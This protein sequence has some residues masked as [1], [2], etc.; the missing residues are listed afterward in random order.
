HPRP[1]PAHSGHAQIEQRYIGLVHAEHLHRLV[2]V[3][4]FG[5]HRHIILH[6]DDGGDSHSRHQFI[7]TN[8]NLNFI[9]HGNGTVTSTSVPAPGLLSNLSSPPSRSAR[10]RIPINPKCPAREENTSC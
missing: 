8:K 1:P 9:G 10:S 5:Y 3:G 4:G 2:P 7:F 6:V